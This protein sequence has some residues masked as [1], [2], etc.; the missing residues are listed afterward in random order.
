MTS[1]G[2]ALRSLFVFC[3]IKVRIDMI[4]SLNTLP[5][6]PHQAQAAS[7]FISSRHVESI[8]MMTYIAAKGIKNR[9]KA[10]S[11]CIRRQYRKRNHSEFAALCS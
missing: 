10:V 5:P 11:D 4:K 6:R 3:V 1:G 9:K 2:I 8:I 7:F